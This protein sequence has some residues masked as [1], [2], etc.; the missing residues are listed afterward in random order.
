MDNGWPLA[1]ITDSLEHVNDLQQKYAAAEVICLPKTT[2]L[3][4]DQVQVALW[5]FQRRPDVWISPTNYGIPFFHPRATRCLLVVLDLIPLLFPRQYLQHRPSWAAMYLIS[6]AVSLLRAD[7]IVAVSDR[8]AAEVRRFTRRSAAVIHPPIP[9]RLSVPD[10]PPIL[11]CPYIVYNGGFDSRKNVPQLLKAFAAFRGTAQG[12]DT[13]LVLLG[14]RQD[15]AR[16]MLATHGLTQAARMTG[17]VSPE[18]KWN[19]LVHASAV[20]YPSSYEGFGLVAA[21]AFAAGV[22]LISGTG[23]ALHEVAGDA[24]IFVDPTSVDS[25]VQGLLSATEPAVRARAIE[26]GY[27]QLEMLRRRSGGYSDLLKH[28]FTPPGPSTLRA[29]RGTD[30]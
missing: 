23:G 10:G 21:E 6:I 11:R 16:D 3:W 17:F 30:T 27:K 24:A 9:D 7:Q 5:L 18:D 2:W 26:R 20:A 15:I 12:S 25:I 22:P 8:T 4:W 1:L 19:Y 29:Y 14:D 28:M 13:L